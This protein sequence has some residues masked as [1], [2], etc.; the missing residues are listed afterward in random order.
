M[1][2]YNLNYI[3]EKNHTADK[4]TVIIQEWDFDKIFSTTWT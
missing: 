4:W 2:V 1:E 3:K